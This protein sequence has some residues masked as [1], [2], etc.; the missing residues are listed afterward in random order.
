MQRNSGHDGSSPKPKLW[1][2]LGDIHQNCTSITIAP[3]IRFQK[4]V[5][6]T[7]QNALSRRVSGG[8]GKQR[9]RRRVDGWSTWLRLGLHRLAAAADGGGSGDYPG[10]TRHRTAVC[11]WRR[12]WSDRGVDALFTVQHSVQ[13][14][15]RSRRRSLF[16]RQLFSGRHDLQ[17]VADSAVSRWSGVRHQSDAVRSHRQRVPLRHCRAGRRKDARNNSSVQSFSS[18]LVQCVLYYLEP[19]LAVLLAPCHTLQINVPSPHGYSLFSVV[20]PFNAICS[21]LLLFK[22]SSAV[23]V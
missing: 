19:C 9:N 18:V 10:Q 7:E 15:H 5:D 6:A 23:L 2:H 20:N 14:A 3:P 11:R 13:T 1:N 4:Y 17:F 16:E 22:G 21:K 8:G 12:R